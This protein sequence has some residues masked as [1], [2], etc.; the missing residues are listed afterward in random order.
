MKRTTRS[1]DSCIPCLPWHS[2]HPTWKPWHSSQDP[3]WP[4]PCSLPKHT[5]VTLHLAHHSHHS[6]LCIVPGTQ[7][8]AHFCLRAFELV[9]SSVWNA[10]PLTLFSDLCSPISLTVRAFLSKITRVLSILPQ[11]SLLHFSL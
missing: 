8:R 9:I 6:G 2:F 10:L 11:D 3:G 1:G 5:S 4:S 7:S